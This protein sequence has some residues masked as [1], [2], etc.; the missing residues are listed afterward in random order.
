MSLVRVPA[1]YQPFGLPFIADVWQSQGWLVFSGKK[2]HL[3]AEADELI[4]IIYDSEYEALEN[5]QHA[6][7]ADPDDRQ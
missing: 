6:A 2:H 5:P 3:H 7:E 4:A 1:V